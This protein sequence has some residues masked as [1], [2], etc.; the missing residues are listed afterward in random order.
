MMDDAVLQL[1]KSVDTPTV[2]NAVEV[3]Q[4]KRGF[5]AFTRG[6][7]FAAAPG[8][9]AIVGYARTAKIAGKFPSPE[10][11]E[12]VRERRMA[13]YRHMAQAP[14]P[15][16]AVIEDLDFPDCVGAFWGEINATVHKGFGMSGVLTN[17]VVRDL[18]DLPEGFSV[19]AG[20]VGPSHAFVHV[21]GFGMPVEVFGITVRPGDLV[22]ADRHG[23]VV[24]P[25]DVVGGLPEA[26][27][28]LIE[29]EKIV[30]DVARLPDFDLE[31]FEVAWARFERART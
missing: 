18:G 28:T 19:I 29:T 25:P 20:S 26:I 27:R 7:P 22:H 31:K 9:P 13:Y 14:R 24:I 23:A 17:G 4:G 5:S 3:V 6:T 15:S 10:S 16:I 12:A 21:T 2:C 11:A 30:L 8:A 1:L